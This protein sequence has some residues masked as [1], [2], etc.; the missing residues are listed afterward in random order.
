MKHVAFVERK[1]IRR[2][3]P[4]WVNLSIRQREVDSVNYWD[5]LVKDDPQGT[6]MLPK[7]AV[8]IDL[9]LNSF[10]NGPFADSFSFS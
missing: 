6:E 9:H 7:A 3:Y 4:L 1:G 10:Y 2:L 8:L 5:H